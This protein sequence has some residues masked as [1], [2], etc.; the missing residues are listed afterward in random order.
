MAVTGRINFI[1]PPAAGLVEKPYQLK[2]EAPE[3]FPP[4]NIVSAE[5]GCKIDDIRGRKNEFSIAT[6]GFCILHLDE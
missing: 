3:G 2:Y 5:H 1:Q 4:T 6:H